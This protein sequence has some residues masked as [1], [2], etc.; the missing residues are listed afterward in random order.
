[1]HNLETCKNCKGLY[2]HFTLSLQYSFNWKHPFPLKTDDISSWAWTQY[3]QPTKA[4]A[5]TYDGAATSLAYSYTGNRRN[6]YSCDVN[7]NVTS[8]ATKNKKKKGRGLL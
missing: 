3:G 6:N 4:Y 7:G 1:M 5:F 2:S 8:D